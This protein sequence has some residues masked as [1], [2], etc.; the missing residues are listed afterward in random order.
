VTWRSVRA[1]AELALGRQRS[2]THDT[3]PHMTRY[4]RAANVK[5]GVLDLSDVKEMNFDPKEQ[6]VFA[7][8][9]GDALVTEGSGSINAVG[10]SSV[11]NG[12]LDGTV[13]FQ[14][15]L[16][17]LRPRAGTDPR[18][19]G[20]WCRHAF[21]DGLFASVATG[22]NIYHLSAE[23]IRALPMK[24]VPLA[25]QR[26]IADYLDVE[27]ARIDALIAKKQQLIHLLE[28][29]IDAAI[30]EV[31]GRSEIA[32]TGREPS[33]EIRRV[34]EK[35]DRTPLVD[36]M[37]T[38]FRDGQVTSRVV[39]GKEGFTNSWTEN[40]RVQGV[41]VGDIV[42]HGLDG[43][44]GAIGDSEA[45]GVCSPVYHVCHP[46]D[47][48]DPAFYGRLLRRLA[49]TGYLG[50]FA[51]STRERAVDFRNWDLFGHIP[52]PLVPIEQQQEIGS[53]IRTLRPLID[54]VEK[55]EVLAA[56]RKS[57]LIS[58]VVSGEL[59]V[60]EPV[61]VLGVPGAGVA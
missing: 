32:A 14:N 59:R 23:R 34:L 8:R 43:F 33:V 6:A 51:V 49:M 10:A 61:Q 9:P 5:D 44:S 4:L 50:N 1:Y 17:R 55:S 7:L 37:I 41:A 36:E 57:A 26:A 46:R 2:P 11:W 29:R 38:A 25:E 20:W 48:G 27:T 13:C 54:L 12:E 15:T 19:L 28:E 22:A 18:F 16:L 40:A 58:E 21:A 53:R 3:G 31:V 24:L 30:M 35:L 39:R 45:D 56:E 47:R 52:I 42:V 60:A